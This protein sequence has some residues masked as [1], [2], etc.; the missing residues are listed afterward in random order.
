MR[1]GKLV[2]I[3]IEGAGHVQG[4]GKRPAGGKGGRKN[5]VLINEGGGRLAGEGKMGEQKGGGG[6]FA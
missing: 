3:H 6:R 5:Y 4:R 1:K 2:A